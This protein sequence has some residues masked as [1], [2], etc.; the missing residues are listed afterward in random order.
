MGPRSRE[1]RTVTRGRQRK[2]AATRSR[3]PN[4][5]QA[6]GGGS[7]G[8]RC[9]EG[10]AHDPHHS[11]DHEKT[12]HHCT[13]RRGVAGTVVA[14]SRR[15]SAPRKGGLGLAQADL[16]RSARPVAYSYGALG[17]IPRRPTALAASQR[18]EVVVRPPPTASLW[19]AARNAGSALVTAKQPSFC[20]LGRVVLSNF[21]NEASG[22][23]WPTARGFHRQLMSTQGGMRA[24]LSAHGSPQR[25]TPKGASVGSCS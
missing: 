4:A 3:A 14:D 7:V 10:P 23:S 16:A 12:P 6:R 18:L 8:T 13:S 5:R 20:A 25:N 11:P 19:L 21:Q 17:S 15:R 22:P 1:L 2:R 24:E 9:Q